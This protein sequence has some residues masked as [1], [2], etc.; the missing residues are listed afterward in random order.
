M[1][2]S[3]VNQHVETVY[4]NAVVLRQVQTNQRVGPHRVN[5][6][7]YYVRFNDGKEKWVDSCEVI[8]QGV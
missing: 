6:L 8:F 3:L 1:N 7:E 2:T 5:F 4:G